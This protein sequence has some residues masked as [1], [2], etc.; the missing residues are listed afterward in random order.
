MVQLSQS[1]LNFASGLGIVL[2]FWRERASS[3]DLFSR[4]TAEE[5]VE[6]FCYPICYRTGWHGAGLGR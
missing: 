6:P 3:A 4:G 1:V 2:A 5:H